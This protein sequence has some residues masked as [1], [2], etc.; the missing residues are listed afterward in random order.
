MSIVVSKQLTTRTNQP[1]LPI[2]IARQRLKL[3]IF[4]TSAGMHAIALS[5]GCGLIRRPVPNKEVI[6]PHLNMLAIPIVTTGL[7]NPTGE[8]DGKRI[9][10]G[11]RSPQLLVLV[12]LLLYFSPL[13]VSSLW[14]RTPFGA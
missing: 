14:G 4:T 1:T 12:S 7:L 9:H 6:H 5:P 3:L 8:E 13:S 11:R 2:G 10:F